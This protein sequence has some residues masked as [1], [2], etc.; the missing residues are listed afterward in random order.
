VK[1]TAYMST[2]MFTIREMEESFLQCQEDCGEHRCTDKA[3]ELMD[4]AEAF[5]S[6]SLVESKGSA[7]GKLIYSLAD[8]MCIAFKTCGIKGK[9]LSGTSK[10]NHKVYDLF[11]MMQNSVVTDQCPHVRH[12]KNE[13]VYNMF[14]PII[15]A[16][17]RS[18]YLRDSQE[19]EDVGVEETAGATFAAIIVPR[20]SRCS[21]SDARVIDENMKTGADGTSFIQVKQ[22]LERNYKCMHITCEDIGGFYHKGVGAYHGGADPCVTPKD[23]L[24]IDLKKHISWSLPLFI[25]GSVSFYFYSKR[26]MRL[27]KERLRRYDAENDLSDS[28]DDDDNNMV[29]G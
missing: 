20:I 12:G 26:R 21:P 15:Q 22:A 10:V 27:R 17:L 4:S 25:I 1:A 29:Y 11:N 2:F 9:S 14:I 23:G 16:T 5:Y 3:L 19:A 24:D 28:D 7:H 18:A 6:G 13:V 8:D